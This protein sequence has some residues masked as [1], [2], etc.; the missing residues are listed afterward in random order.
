MD[1]NEKQVRQGLISTREIA[2]GV[3]VSVIEEVRVFWRKDG[4]RSDVD[5]MLHKIILI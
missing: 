4:S 2:W 1:K 5:A 3:H